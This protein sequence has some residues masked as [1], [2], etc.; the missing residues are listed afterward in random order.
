MSSIETK[1]I[2]LIIENKGSGKLLENFNFN[3]ET[4]LFLKKIYNEYENFIKNRT[5]QLEDIGFYK[6]INS[7][8]EKNCGYCYKLSRDIKVIITNMNDGVYYEPNIEEFDNDMIYV[9]FI[10]KSL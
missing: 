10:L 8:I 3:E 2:N 7:I 5:N 1:K 9:K 4:I 6:N